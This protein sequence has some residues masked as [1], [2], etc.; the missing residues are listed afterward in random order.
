MLCFEEFADIFALRRIK[1]RHMLD[2]GALVR[3]FQRVRFEDLVADQAQWS[4][5]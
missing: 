1:T 5:S 3:R 2:A 4:T